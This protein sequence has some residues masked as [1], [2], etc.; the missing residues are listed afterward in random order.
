MLSGE[1]EGGGGTLKKREETRGCPNMLCYSFIFLF[2]PSFFVTRE[3][4]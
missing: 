2:L 3:R 1:R 4:R